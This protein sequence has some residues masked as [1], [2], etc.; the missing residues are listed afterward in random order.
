VPE[1]TAEDAGAIRSLMN[2]RHAALRTPRQLTRFLCGITSPATSRARLTKHDLFGHL[3][4]V[5]FADVL[6]QTECM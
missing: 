6:A 4:R 5:P 1:I 2:E 3:E